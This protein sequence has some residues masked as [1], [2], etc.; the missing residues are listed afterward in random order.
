MLIYD[1]CSCY[2]STIHTVHAMDLWYTLF[3]LSISICDVCPQSTRYI[4]PSL[5]DM[6]IL[7]VVILYILSI[8][9]TCYK[10]YRSICIFM[11][12]IFMHPMYTLI[13]MITMFSHSS[14]CVILHL[15]HVLIRA[16]SSTH[17]RFAMHA[18]HAATLT[19]T[20]RCTLT[21]RWCFVLVY[22]CFS[23]CATYDSWQ[24]WYGGMVF[25]I[26]CQWLRYISTPLL[27][28]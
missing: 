12:S 23:P 11:L 17:S 18:I 6:I 20:I 14:D 3:I 1:A 5:T 9:N 24:R 26:L 7:S 16:C 8:Y 28:G 19:C 13:T 22:A 4:L 2:G 27:R 21:T 15:V 25:F 10:C